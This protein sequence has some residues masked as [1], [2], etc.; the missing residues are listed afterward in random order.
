MA[1]VYGNSNIIRKFK[2]K[3]ELTLGL[4]L[5]DMLIFSKRK[6]LSVENAVKHFLAIFEM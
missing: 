1:I 6:S 5:D 3:Y 2:D 4:P